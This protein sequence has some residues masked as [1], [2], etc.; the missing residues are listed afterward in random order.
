MRHLEVPLAKHNKKKHSILAL[1]VM[2]FLFIIVC[3]IGICYFFSMP[4]NSSSTEQIDFI[5]KNGDST[6][7]IVKNLYADNLIKNETFA[8]YYA[9]IFKP[10]F[11]SG[12][13]ML[14][15]NMSLSEIFAEL[16][17]GKQ[18][19]VK[20]T[21]P[22]GLTLTKLAGLLEEKLGISREQFLELV[23]SPEP[24]AAYGVV[25]KTCEGFLYPDTYFFTENETAHSIV[26]TLIETFFN[27]VK[28]ISNFPQDAPTILETVKLASIVERE[29]R[30]VDEAPVIAGVFQNRLN[31]GMA[32]QSCTTIEY[33]ITEIQKKPHPTRIFF[34]DLE[35][36][37]PYNTY[38]YSGL[39]P[40]PICSPGFTAL[41]AVVSPHVHDY[42][43]FRLIN[44]SEGRHAFSKTF[45]EHNRNEGIMLKG[46]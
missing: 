7:H 27:K 33:I 36:D 34:A 17:T 15:S 5:I 35:I 29:Y 43:Y 21:I 26:T 37:N 24:L 11:K 46:N 14:S 25:A 19:M 13:Y 32:L 40:T 20:I 22:E 39:P 45:Y 8:Y 2:F 9:R 18:K 4:V 44:E 31:I 28:T 10:A 3:G 6:F 42:L 38:I 16:T 41:Q 30:L 1:I 12:S 23:N